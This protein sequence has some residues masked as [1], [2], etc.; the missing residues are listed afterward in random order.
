VEEHPISASEHSCMLP[1]SALSP[2]SS[3]ITASFSL[4][5]SSRY[6]S[7]IAL[8]RSSSSSS[9]NFGDK[10]E[11]TFR[12]LYSSVPF[13]RKDTVESITTSTYLDIEQVIL[14]YS[15]LTSWRGH[16]LNADLTLDLLDTGQICVARYSD[17]AS[18][19][20]LMSIA[21]AQLSG[22]ITIIKVLDYLN[23]KIVVAGST[24]GEG[25]AWNISYVVSNITCIERN[26]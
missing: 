5:T 13:D 9:P 7:S 21:S 18:L 4:D 10:D 1:L 17:M 16:F 19:T 15:E 22:S 12:C 23:R 6:S 3:F 24:H 8:R 25:G 2:L 14:G 11:R 20:E 26:S